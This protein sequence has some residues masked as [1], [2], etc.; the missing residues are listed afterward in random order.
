M[1]VVLK[2]PIK[3]ALSLATNTT[4]SKLNTIYFSLYFK[5][6]NLHIY[7]VRKKSEKVGSEKT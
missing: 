7:R 4:N 5:T 6:N 2:N 3:I 1:F